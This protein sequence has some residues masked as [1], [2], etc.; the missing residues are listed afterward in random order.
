MARF[1]FR[2]EVCGNELPAE[3]VEKRVPGSK[4]MTRAVP[5]IICE[6]DG[7]PMVREAFTP[8]DRVEKRR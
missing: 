7:E 6:K 8:A 4:S 2:C 3:R 5:V 1:R